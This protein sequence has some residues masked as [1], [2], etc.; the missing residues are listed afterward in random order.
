[1]VQSLLNPWRNLH[2]KITLNIVLERN[3]QRAQKIQ[4]L[5]RKRKYK[6]GEM[7][8]IELLAR[9]EDK[10]APALLPAQSALTL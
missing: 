1:L 9:I 6:K 8:V 4:N 5:V 7:L 2:Q 10:K 3:A